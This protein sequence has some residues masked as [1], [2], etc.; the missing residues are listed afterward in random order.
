MIINIISE[1]GENDGYTIQ[2]KAVSIKRTNEMIPAIS[3][4]YL[5]K[6]FNEMEF[7]TNLML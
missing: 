6:L 7:L 5:L 3:I 1:G 4:K 2:V